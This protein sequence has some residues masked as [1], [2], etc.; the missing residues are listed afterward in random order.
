ML[1]MYT[2]N[3]KFAFQFDD[4]EELAENPEDYGIEHAIDLNALGGPGASALIVLTPSGQGGWYHRRVIGADDLE[5]A[6]AMAGLLP[7]DPA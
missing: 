1:D 3:G 5:R 7:Q 2:S 6:L 4:I